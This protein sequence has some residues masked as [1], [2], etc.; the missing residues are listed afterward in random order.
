QDQLHPGEPQE[1]AL[2]LSRET[3]PGKFNVSF[4][5]GFVSSQ[6]FV[7]RFAKFGAISTLLPDDADQGLDFV[8]THPKEAQA[9][10]WMGFEARRSILE[11]L[12]AAIL[13]PTATVRVVA[14]DLNEP[15]VV[16]RLEQLGPRLRVII[17]DSKDHK[18][19]ESAESQSELRLIASAGAAN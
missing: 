12:D 14:Y 1:A 6:A 15:E 13:D 4:T 9:K 3:V 16:T 7:D 18:P 11:V 10:D 8:A 2:E 17:D 5:R 19:P